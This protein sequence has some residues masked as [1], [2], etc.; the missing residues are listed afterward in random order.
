MTERCSTELPLRLSVDW[1]RTLA[2]SRVA[3]S[4]PAERVIDSET[5]IIF[6]LLCKK[7]DDDDNWQDVAAFRHVYRRM[8]RGDRRRGAAGKMSTPGMTGTFREK[9]WV[10]TGKSCRVVADV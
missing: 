10:M 8:S 1:G 7:P 3:R 5:L 9:V 2:A 4:V 6:C